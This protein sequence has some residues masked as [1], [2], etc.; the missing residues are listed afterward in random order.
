MTSI[1]KNA[2][3]DS[4]HGHRVQLSLALSALAALHYPV[5]HRRYPVYGK[6]VDGI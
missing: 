3:D 4:K 6:G 2:W 5:Y 1:N